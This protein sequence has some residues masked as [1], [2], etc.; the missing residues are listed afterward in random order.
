[1]N[2]RRPSRQVIV[3]P[4]RLVP[5]LPSSLMGMV[6]AGRAD[7]RRPGQGSVTRAL[8]TFALPKP[9]AMN[10]MPVGLRCCT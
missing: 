8:P 4:A 7:R 6:G 3:S 2:R 10:G 1:M 5:T 9:V